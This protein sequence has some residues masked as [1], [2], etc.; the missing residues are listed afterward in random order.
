MVADGAVISAKSRIGDRHFSRVTL[1]VLATVP[2]D[3]AIHSELDA[4][5]SDPEV[6]AQPESR[7]AQPSRKKKDVVNAFCT[8]IMKDM[9]VDHEKHEAVKEIDQVDFD[10]E[11]VIKIRID[12][13]E[14]IR[15]SLTK[16]KFWKAGQ[17]LKHLDRNKVRYAYKICVDVDKERFGELKCFQGRRKKAKGGQVK[18]TGKKGTKT[19]RKRSDDWE[20][21][22]YHAIAY[23]VV[24]VFEGLSMVLYVVIHPSGEFPQTD[25]YKDH[26]YIKDCLVK[27]LEVKEMKLLEGDTYGD[28]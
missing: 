20:E 25:E 8:V 18:D 28:D 3:P 19:K 17:D 12:I 6:E 11:E 24:P 21:Y 10:N 27:R 2:Y 4:E 23:R 16:K 22:I 1:G 14:C 5:D 13:V 15:S 7:T 26:H 9:P